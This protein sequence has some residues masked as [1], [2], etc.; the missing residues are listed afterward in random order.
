M[1]LE[2]KHQGTSRH[3]VQPTRL[4]LGYLP[5]EVVVDSAE[6]DSSAGMPLPVADNADRTQSGSEYE[7]RFPG[8][9]GSAEVH[10]IGVAIRLAVSGLPFSFLSYFD[11][12]ALWE[13][14]RISLR[15]PRE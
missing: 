2:P 10:P 4:C 12:I 6:P 8:A 11:V 14:H 3:S 5:A 1:E 13:I 9:A 7:H 15:T